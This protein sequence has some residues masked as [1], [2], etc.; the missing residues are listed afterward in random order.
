VKR[1]PIGRIV[2]I[3]GVHGEVKCDPTSAGRALFADGALLEL[4]SQRVRDSVR[5][6]RARDHGK[7]LVLSIAGV[8]EVQ[9]ARQRIGATFYAPREAIR[10]EPG[11]FLDADLIGCV[12]CDVS[13][14]SLGTISAV[15][16][17]PG[18]DMLIV[19]G[20]MIPLVAA[21]VRDI[22]VAKQRIVVELPPGLFSSG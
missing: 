6:T 10:L 8:E 22:D 4:E 17:Y 11:E 15:H 7:R 13:G 9:S 2:G 19:D 1:V 16:H 18:S 20:Q 21:F 12:M 3:F 5:I 14:R